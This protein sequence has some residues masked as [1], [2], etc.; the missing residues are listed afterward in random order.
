MSIQDLSGW[1]CCDS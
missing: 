1:I